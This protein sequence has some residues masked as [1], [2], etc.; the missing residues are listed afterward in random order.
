MPATISLG[1]GLRVDYPTAANLAVRNVMRSNRKRNTKPEVALRSAL[2]SRGLRFRNDASVATGGRSI[3]V[4]ITLPR[5]RVAIFVDGCFWHCCP[6]HGSRP[7]SN[8]EYWQT[9][10]ARNVERDAATNELL[11]AAGWRVIRV[12]EHQDPNE[13]AGI[14]HE[15]VRCSV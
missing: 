11:Q 7:R 9:K 3:R 6:E 10:L 5:H 14:I 4:D 1:A 12:W 2:D 15:L 13:V 8:S